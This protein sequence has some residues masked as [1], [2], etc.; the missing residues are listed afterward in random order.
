MLTLS[1]KSRSHGGW[2]L[3]ELCPHKTSSLTRYVSCVGQKVGFRLLTTTSPER[4][5][6]GETKLTYWG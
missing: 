5:L 6:V 1:L 3:G 2:G 4:H